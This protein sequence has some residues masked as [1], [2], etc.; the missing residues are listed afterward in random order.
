MGMLSRCMAFKKAGDVLCSERK[1][2]ALLY[3]RKVRTKYEVKWI[4]AHV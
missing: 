3:Q 2:E 1:G 4:I